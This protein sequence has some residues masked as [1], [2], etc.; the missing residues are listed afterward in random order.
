MYVCD[1]A[2]AVYKQIML[3]VVG[4]IETDELISLG[5]KIKY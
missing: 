2:R 5:K 4:C 3:R 1:F